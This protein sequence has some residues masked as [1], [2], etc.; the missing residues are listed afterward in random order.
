MNIEQ[1]NLMDVIGKHNSIIEAKFD[2]LLQLIEKGLETD[3]GHHKQWYLE[4]ILEF[5]SGVSVDDLRQNG[6]Y[7][8][9]KGIAP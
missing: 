6:C 1:D 9:E 7:Y 5:V 4:Q 2:Q 8:G 3:G